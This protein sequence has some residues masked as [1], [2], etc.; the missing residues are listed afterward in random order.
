MKNGDVVLLEN[1]RYRKEETKNEE[2][3]SKELASLADIFVIDAFGSSHRAHC[4]TV[5]VT[6]FVDESAVGYLMEKE[7]EYL[8]NAVNNP[9][10]PFVAILGGA[11]VSDKINVINNLLDK[12]D[13][14]IIGGGMAYT[15]FAAKGYS[16]GT[17]LLEEDKISY[18]K[19]MMEKA[20]QKVLNSLFH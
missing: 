8:G 3:F 12:V 4:S 18:A 16:V 6:K 1:T 15:F 14:I 11:K 19:E 7:I 2:S 9:V 10:R 17:S 5:G 20:E 13:T